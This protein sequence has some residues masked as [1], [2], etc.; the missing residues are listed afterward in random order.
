MA[1][2][3]HARGRRHAEQPDVGGEPDDRAEH[4]QVEQ[5]DERLRRDPADVQLC[6]L[7]RYE[8]CEDQRGAAQVGYGDAA[9]ILGF[10]TC[11]LL[12]SGKDGRP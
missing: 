2:E 1:G 8:A 9:Y 3:E 12:L 6:G 7:V 4:D 10:V 11:F 5:R